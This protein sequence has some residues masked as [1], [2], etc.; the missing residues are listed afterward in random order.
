MV[1]PLFLLSG[2]WASLIL[3]FSRSLWLG[4]MVIG[5][6]IFL[7][8]TWSWRVNKRHLTA[9]I[10]GNGVAITVSFFLLFS[11]SLIPIPSSEGAF[12]IDS[13]T[14]RVK[15]IQDEAAAASR[16]NLL[17]VLAT[18]IAHQPL[19]GYGFGKTVTYVS[20]DPRVLLA[21]TSGEY[22]TYAFEWGYLDMMVK[23][24]LL[25]L[26]VYLC[27]IRELFFQGLS[28]LKRNTHERGTDTYALISGLIFGIG[29]LLVIHMF[30]PYLNHP[31]GIGLIIFCGLLFERLSIMKDT[32]E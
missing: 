26:L 17:P 6:F 19:L 25:G 3:S 15:D 29:A 8:T 12:T 32:R 4:T 2:S 13:L 10:V 16:W 14:D 20:H 22:V 31:L 24:G 7:I 21:H 11:I 23:L 9:W 5:L 30:T 18:V 27:M 1:M 28:A